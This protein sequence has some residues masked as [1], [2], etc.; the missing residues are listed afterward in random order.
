MADQQ[1]KIDRGNV[2][3]YFAF[4]VGF[5]IDLNLAE[6]R[7]TQFAERTKVRQNKRAPW[8]FEFE[9]APL[10]LT[11]PMAEISVGN[12]KA[13][14][15]AEAT[16]F[17]FGAISVAINI[18]F[19]GTLDS[20][21]GLSYA[22]Y[23]N[24]ELEKHSR[25]LV[26][27]LVS[28]IS[29]AISK[30]MMNEHFEEYKIFQV[31][32]SSLLLSDLL[33]NNLQTLAK[34]LRSEEQSLSDDEVRDATW[35]YLSYT[36]NDLL[37]I[38]WNTAILFDTKA[39]DV[40]S[41]LEFANV[42]LLELTYLDLKLDHSL[43]RAYELV[44]KLATR[45]FFV[46]GHANSEL[47]RIGRMQADSALLFE[48]I[49]NAIKL[50]GD[51]YLARVYRL[52]SARFHLPEWDTSILRKINALESMYEKLNDQSSTFRMETLEWIIILLILVS[53]LLPFVMGTP[54][55]V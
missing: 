11:Y 41:V 44:S 17:D 47:R 5:S 23:E 15:E 20:L 32:E 54:I 53:I 33:K 26:E 36:P 25:Q 2:Y 38:D 37:L 30:M 35:A 42:E 55:K 52:A 34:I 48:G 24:E 1:V 9:P 21:V 27:S 51:Q 4:D 8:Y 14:P 10:K 31:K 19:S 40:R 50:L 18:P 45:R 28:T 12:C 7:F 16:I 43:D 13:L 39:Q 29:P 49:N 3:V 46:P 22:L 6:K